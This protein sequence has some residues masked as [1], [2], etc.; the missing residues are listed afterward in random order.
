M[1]EVNRSREN[2]VEENGFQVNSPAATTL[3]NNENFLIR[4]GAENGLFQGAWRSEG[5]WGRTLSGA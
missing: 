3:E 4:E 5:N 1:P 2:L